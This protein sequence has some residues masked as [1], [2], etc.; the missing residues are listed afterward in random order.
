M[1]SYYGTD[2]RM[3]A[4][5]PN[6]DVHTSERFLY[7]SA[8]I[9]SVDLKALA[10]GGK[11]AARLLVPV[12]DGTL[13]ATRLHADDNGAP[14]TVTGPVVKGAPVFGQVATIV[15]CDVGLW[16]YW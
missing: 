9:A 3:A 5:S 13:S 2:W 1:T 6:F 15:S 12:A 16:V 4:D 7:L 10:N 14:L 11:R 8:P